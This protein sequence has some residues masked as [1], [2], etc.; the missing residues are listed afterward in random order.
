[1]VESSSPPLKPL[2][3]PINSAT[4]LLNQ[5]MEISSSI[6]STKQDKE[7]GGDI[8]AKTVERPSHPPMEQRIIDYKAQEHPLMKWQ[9]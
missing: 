1:M 7:E 9:Q 5:V 8:V 4:T 3:V 6:P 2:V